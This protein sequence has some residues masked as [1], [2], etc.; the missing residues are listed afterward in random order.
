MGTMTASSVCLSVL[1][2][3][4]WLRPHLRR[5]GTDT[6]PHPPWGSLVTTG[7]LVVALVVGVLLPAINYFALL[8]LFLTGPIEA[9]LHRRGA[10]HR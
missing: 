6:Q 8:L 3:P 2:V 9:R 7:T 5:E 1:S 4:V 10:V